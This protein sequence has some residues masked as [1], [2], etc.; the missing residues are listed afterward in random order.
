MSCGGMSNGGGR[1][2]LGSGMRKAI[3]GT[4]ECKAEAAGPQ[5][6]GWCGTAG[7]AEFTQF[8]RIT[9]AGLHHQSRSAFP[10]PTPIFPTV[11]YFHAYCNSPEAKV[12]ML[13]EQA[14]WFMDVDAGAP[15]G[16]A[17]SSCLP[18]CSLW[19]AGG[20]AATAG[21]R[22]GVSRPLCWPTH[23]VLQARCASCW[24]GGTPTVC[25]MPGVTSF[26]VSPTPCRRGLVPAQAGVGV[27]GGGGV[28]ALGVAAAKAGAAGD[29]VCQRPCAIP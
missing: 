2:C 12:V 24:A 18:N 6:R 19:L 10:H 29:A 13:K 22:L 17:S 20:L 11:L 28:Q 15:D 8:L 14:L 23:P 1:T 26:I 16:H 5:Q 7:A 4:L 27:G 9:L 3:C 21:P 25:T